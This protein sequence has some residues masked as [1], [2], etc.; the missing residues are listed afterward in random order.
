MCH[1]ARG[2]FHEL[3]S[4]RNLAK[5]PENRKEVS[6]ENREELDKSTL[7]ETMSDYWLGVS[8]F[9]GIIQHNN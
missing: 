3:P 6:P 2:I 9:R 8:M 5:Y 7:D 1:R 4:S